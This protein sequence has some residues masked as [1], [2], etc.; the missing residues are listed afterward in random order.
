MTESRGDL[1]LVGKLLTLTAVVLLAAG[2]AAAA[3]WLP[4]APGTTRALAR[5][6]L[7]IGGLDLAMALLFMVRYR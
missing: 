2:G 1:L 3:G 5:V 4:S 7:T 6:L